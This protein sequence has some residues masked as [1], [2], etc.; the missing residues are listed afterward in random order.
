MRLILIVIALV[1]AMDADADQVLRVD[2]D[3]IRLTYAPCTL[4][5]VGTAAAQLNHASGWIKGKHYAACWTASADTV[6]MVF[7][8]GDVGVWPAGRFKDEPGV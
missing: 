5:L 6:W 2:A 7:E 3:S 1:L 4:A 8:D